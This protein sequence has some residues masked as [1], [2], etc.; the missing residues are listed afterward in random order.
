QAFSVDAVTLVN[1]VRARAG[2]ALLNSSP[3][4]MVT[5]QVDL[6][7]RIRNERRR[8]FPNEGIDFFDEMRWKTW[9]EKVFA[10]GNGVKQIWGANVSTYSWQGDYIYNW[11]IPATEIQM[12]SALTQN[13]GWIN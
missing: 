5:T 8:E 6:R 12:N 10:A 11:P 1:S 3:A 4:T 2:V 13:A 9:E 7:E